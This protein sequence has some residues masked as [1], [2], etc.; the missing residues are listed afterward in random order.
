MPPHNT[1]HAFLSSYILIL[2]P[3]ALYWCAQSS[4]G[5]Y[6][7]DAENSAGSRGGGGGSGR[8]ERS[9]SPRVTSQD[10]LHPQTT[11]VYGMP[12]LSSAI[13]AQPHLAV[14]AFAVSGSNLG[15]SKQNGGN[16]NVTT[17]QPHTHVHIAESSSRISAATFAATMR[18]RVCDDETDQ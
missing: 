7:G 18:A 15:E 8:S 2:Q 14:H 9:E 3:F 17:V 5:P 4:S 16:V 12:S 6:Q 11:V 1:I 10:P 13:L